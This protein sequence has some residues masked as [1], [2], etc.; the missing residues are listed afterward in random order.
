M[1]LATNERK[2]PFSRILKKRKTEQ[3]I[4]PIMSSNLAEEG[5]KTNRETHTDLTRTTAPKRTPVLVKVVRT[6]ETE[7]SR[8]G[9]EKLFRLID[10]DFSTNEEGRDTVLQPAKKRARI[11]K[12]YTVSI[13]TKKS[14]RDYTD[15]ELTEKHKQADRNLITSWQSIISKYEQLGD[16]DNG[17]D[18]IDLRTGKIIEDNG[19]IKALAQQDTLRENDRR[20]KLTKSSKCNDDDFLNGL[21]ED[22]VVKEAVKRKLDLKRLKTDGILPDLELDLDDSDDSS[23]ESYVLESDDYS[24][25]DVEVDNEIEGKDYSASVD[26]SDG[27]EDTGSDPGDDS[28]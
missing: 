1:A 19:H 12:K 3:P 27:E 7:H 18:I 23:D 21:V 15:K 9:H 6:N 16:T 22:N 13:D 10:P 26:S 24:D 11:S 4:V 8:D 17:S 25:S 5:E 20:N 2:D 28:T 14:I